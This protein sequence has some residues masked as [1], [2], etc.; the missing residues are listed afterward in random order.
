[1]KKIKEYW[2]KF[3]KLTHNKNFVFIFPLAAITFLSLTPPRVLGFI[4]LA[5]WCVVVINN[6]HDEKV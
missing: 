5:I 2:D 1:M 4:L 3:V 6:T